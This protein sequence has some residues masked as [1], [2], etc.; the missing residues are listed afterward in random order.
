MSKAVDRSRRKR[1]ADL[2]L[3]SWCMMLSVPD[4]WTVLLLYVRMNPD[5]D[6][7]NMLG[8]TSPRPNSMFIIT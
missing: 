2:V 6:G 1:A 7:S 5:W 3:A 4:M 8:F